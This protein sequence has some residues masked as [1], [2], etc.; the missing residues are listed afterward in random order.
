MT[1]PTEHRGWIS[2]ISQIAVRAAVA[3]AVLFG[4]AVVTSS[5][6]QAQT[7][8]VLYTSMGGTDAANPYA[9]LIRDNA[10]NFYGTSLF[11][12]GTCGCGTVFKLDTGGNET[13]LYSFN[14]GADGASPYAALVRDP[15]DNLYGTTGSYGAYL[16]GTVFELTKAG[17][18]TTLHGFADGTDGGVLY[19][20]LIRDKAGN[21][22]GTADI[23]GDLTCNPGTFPG[24]GVAFKL[25]TSGTET[26]LHSFIGGADG[27]FPQQ[28]LCRTS[29]A[30]SIALLAQA[31]FP[32]PE[33]CSR[34]RAR[35]WRP[36][37]TVSLAGRTG[38]IP[39]LVWSGTE[40]GTFTARPTAAVTSR[41]TRRT[42]AES[43]SSLPRV[44][45][46]C[47]TLS[48]VGQMGHCPSE[49]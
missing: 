22:Y 8:S 1:N 5:Y 12:G 33:P 30:T 17:K 23:G 35:A 47:F 29:W 40:R 21:L 11:G 46:L 36:Y 44:G 48:L 38:E 39:T 19:G 42:A 6:V 3:F 31:G 34:W 4:L 28:D 49:A 45:R 25:D 16:F 37:C 20:D 7:Y 43:C 13:V 15:E 14:A 2:G 32:T 26:V 18:L 41:V 24:C 10:G 27:A 9:G